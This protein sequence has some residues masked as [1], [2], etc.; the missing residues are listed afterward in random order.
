M[1]NSSWT[2]NHVDSILQHTDTLLD[3]LHILS[4]LSLLHLLHPY[5]PPRTARIVYP[6]CDTREMT[7]FSLERR[8]RVILSIAQFR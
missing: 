3:Y 8:E 2:K 7:K 5:N 1:V 4:P 6:P